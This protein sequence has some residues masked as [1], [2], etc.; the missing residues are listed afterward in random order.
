[1]ERKILISLNA[2]EKTGPFERLEHY[3]ELE[4]Q[5]MSKSFTKKLNA[6]GHLVKSNSPILSRVL[7]A[8]LGYF[9]FVLA[10]SCSF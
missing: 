2:E 10:R 3:L 6:H 7:L 5:G 9:W 4:I 8:C 1:M